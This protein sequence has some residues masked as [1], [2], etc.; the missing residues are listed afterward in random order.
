MSELWGP[1]QWPVEPLDVLALVLAPLALLAVPP[2]FRAQRGRRVVVLLACAAA[3][4]SLGYVGHYLRGGPRIIDATAYWLEGRTLASGALAMP[5][6]SPEASVLGRFLVPTPDATGPAA[7]AVI[8]PPGYPAVLAL[9]FWLRA[10][11]LVGPVLAALLVVAT[12]ALARRAARALD[13]PAQPCAALAGLLSALCAALR[14]HTADTMSHGLAALLTAL[15]VLAA[16]EALERARALGA[17]SG[18]RATLQRLLGPGLALGAAL[19]WLAATRPVTALGL[20]LVLAAAAALGLGLRRAGRRRLGTLA[21]L[22]LVGAVPGLALYLAYEY[23]ATG[24]LGGSAQLAYYAASDGPPGCFG[25]GFGRAVGCLGEHGELVGAALPDG[26]YLAEAL[27]TTGRRL[28]LH[29]GDVLNWRPLVWLVP[30]GALLGRRSREV[31]VLFAAVLAH[32][33]VYAGF[34]FDGNYPGGGARMFADVLP[35][36]HALAAVGVALAAE[37]LRRA[38][39]AWGDPTPE[40]GALVAGLGL[41]GFAG[42]QGR[43][44][45]ALRDREGGAPMFSAAELERAGIER[46]LVFVDGDHGFDLARAPAGPVEAVRYRGDDLDWLTWRAR[47]EPPAYRYRFD[48]ASAE[49]RSGAPARPRVEPLDFLAKDHAQLRIEAESLWPARAQQDGWLW[50]SWGAA[51][52]P[53]RY[54]LLRIA[55]AQG[56]A[57]TATARVALPREL[58]GHAI[59]PRVVLGLGPTGEP[60]PTRAGAGGAVTLT[61]LADDRIVHAWRPAP[62]TGGTECRELEPGVAP[63]AAGSLALELA[64]DVPFALDSLAATLHIDGRNH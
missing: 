64:S 56:A 5:L 33:A 31:R 6:P 61:L 43:L 39:P 63:V 62:P 44:H 51:C 34:Y 46:G 36:E 12:A 15:A 9:G 17:S 41:L 23:R 38:R 16:F 27:G 42:H 10:P 58:A 19:G 22:V 24:V 35:L 2:L 49:G 54:L 26:Y 59:R 45:A 57:T 37:R 55:G 30:L 21:A 13:L 60:V 7:A 14:Y 32:V 53:G 48:W 1:W 28:H 4:L 40:L 11:M 52:A 50:P 8:F 25:W 18:P 29:M 3:A 47:G 20:G